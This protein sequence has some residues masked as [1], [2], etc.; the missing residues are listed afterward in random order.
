MAREAIVDELDTGIGSETDDGDD[1]ESR[2]VK[3]LI[4]RR[5]MRRRRARRIGR[6]RIFEDVF[7]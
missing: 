1:E 6:S 7:D 4:G 3:A 5:M 2:V